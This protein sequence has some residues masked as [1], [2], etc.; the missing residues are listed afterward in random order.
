MLY[1]PST[2]Q[3]YPLQTSLAQHPVSDFNFVGQNDS[4]TLSVVA[5]Q[6]SHP[7]LDASAHPY[8]YSSTIPNYSSFNSQTGTLPVQYQFG[9]HAFDAS[10]HALQPTPLYS[11]QNRS[12]VQRPISPISQPMDASSV[13]QSLD[14]SPHIAV[15]HSFGHKTS[16]SV[17]RPLDASLCVIS[18]SISHPSDVSSHC[19]HDEGHSVHDLLDCRHSPYSTECRSSRP[20]S[21]PPGLPHPPQ[22]QA[23]AAVPSPSVN[24]YSPSAPPGPAHPQSNL[25]PK[26][27]SPK[28]LLPGQNP[29]FT[30]QDEAQ[31]APPTSAEPGTMDVFSLIPLP[32]PFATQLDSPKKKKKRT[33]SKKAK[34]IGMHDSLHTSAS[35]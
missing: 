13:S 23:S 5:M 7:E 24:P 19:V 12:F 10:S 6:Q 14:A 18:S 28:S 17:S 33:K 34:T 31:L 8:V 21:A 29:P 4:S 1:Q 16:S 25:P 2:M 20:P 27:V 11:F 15:E 26:V 35:F 9:S 32:H 22:F 3:N 30:V